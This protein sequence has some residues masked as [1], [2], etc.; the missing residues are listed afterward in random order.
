M[1]VDGFSSGLGLTLGKIRNSY[2]GYN[3]ISRMKHEAIRIENK[4]KS[5]WNVR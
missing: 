2:L 5:E 4:N 1:L 3:R